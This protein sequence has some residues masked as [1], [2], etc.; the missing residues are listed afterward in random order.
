[1]PVTKDRT[2]G[3]RDGAD[4]PVD[5]A[6]PPGQAR[7]LG[8]LRRARTPLRLTEVAARCEAHENTIR[9][10]LEALHERGLVSRTPAA[11]G[12]RGRPAWL[13]AARAT[14]IT[15]TTELAEL[16]VALAG[17]VVRHADDPRAAALEAG[18]AWGEQLSEQSDDTVFEQLVRLGFAPGEDGEEVRLTRCPLLGAAQA[19]PQVICGVHE[20]LVRGMVDARGGDPEEV[21]LLPFAE[22]GCCVLRGPR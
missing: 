9:P 5:A 13:Y 10:Q 20:G 18:H 17:A 6:L 2:L 14:V 21:E 15:P 8:V 12:R 3:P 19:E 22:P 11:T 4:A 1:M 16:A 7:L